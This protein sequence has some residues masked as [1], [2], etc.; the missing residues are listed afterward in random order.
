MF[1]IRLIIRL[2]QSIPYIHPIFKTLHIRYFLMAYFCFCS[3]VVIDLCLTNHDKVTHGSESLLSHLISCLDHTEPYELIH[4][5]VIA[6]V[7]LLLL[8]NLS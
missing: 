6:L 5:S 4:K 2:T 7:G 8:N 3:R 1:I